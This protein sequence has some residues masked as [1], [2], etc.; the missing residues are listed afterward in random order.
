MADRPP[1]Q[2]AV[3]EGRTQ[4]IQ[5]CMTSLENVETG[6]IRMLSYRGLMCAD[7]VHDKYYCVGVLASEH[8]ASA[9][10]GRVQVHPFY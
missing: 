2:A 7:A 10:Q 9:V 1:H 8:D 6:K 4:T 5:P 3:R